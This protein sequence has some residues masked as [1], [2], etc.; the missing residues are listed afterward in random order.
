MR[1]SKHESYIS[2]ILIIVSKGFILSKIFK[3]SEESM[4]FWRLC[5][6]Q[7]KKTFHKQSFINIRLV[8]CV[9]VHTRAIA[10]IKLRQKFMN[11][12]LFSSQTGSFKDRDK[13]KKILL[14]IDFS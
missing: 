1:I 13:E 9:L 5:L 8:A 7:V 11:L 3:C 14:E 4:V 2:N 10:R 12:D 6:P